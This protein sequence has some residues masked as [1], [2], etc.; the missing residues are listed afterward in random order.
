MFI[1][2]G[3][4][5][6]TGAMLQGRCGHG[7]GIVAESPQPAGNV[8]GARTCS[9]KPGPEERGEP[10]V[11]IQQRC[12]MAEPVLRVPSEIHDP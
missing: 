10:P 8:R 1:R 12:A 2:G 9:G 11:K 3:P 6:P 7:L 5:I 4:D